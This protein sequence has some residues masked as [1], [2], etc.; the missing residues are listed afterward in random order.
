MEKGNKDEAFA[1][2]LSRVVDDELWSYEPEKMTNKDLL[3][4]VRPEFIDIK[5]GKGLEGEIYGVM[6]TGMETTLKIRVGDFLLTGVVFG[7]DIFKIGTK[8]KVAFNSPKVML[9]DRKSGKRICSGE[10]EV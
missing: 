2:Q 5:S 7:S 1:Y 9:F 8:V 3:I 4:G 10:L 6:P